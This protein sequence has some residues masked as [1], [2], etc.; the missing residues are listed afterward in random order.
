MKR[1]DQEFINRLLDQIRDRF[2]MVSAQAVDYEDEGEKVHAIEVTAMSQ[3][4][5]GHVLAFAEPL[6]VRHILS[7]G[8]FV[9]LNPVRFAE[10]E[11]VSSVSVSYSS[12]EEQASDQ[13]SQQAATMSRAAWGSPETSTSCSEWYVAQAVPGWDHHDAEGGAT[14][15]KAA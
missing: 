2:P 12:G 9:A 14:Y 7:G 13:A 5:W 6:V 3:K 10:A 11:V 1:S 8:A 15:G 4:A